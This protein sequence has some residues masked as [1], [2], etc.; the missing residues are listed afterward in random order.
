MNLMSSATCNLTFNWNVISYDDRQ[1][2]SLTLQLWA[3][4]SLPLGDIKRLDFSKLL[5]SWGIF[6][7]CLITHADH[8]GGIYGGLAKNLS[9]EY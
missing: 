5:F 7:H 1:Y 9:P 2:N 4:T 6:F 8:R 3:G